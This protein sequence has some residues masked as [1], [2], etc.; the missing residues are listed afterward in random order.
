GLKVQVPLDGGAPVVSAGMRVGP[1]GASVGSDGTLK[2]EWGRVRVETTPESGQVGFGLGTNVALTRVLPYEVSAGVSL[3]LADP[4]RAP[5][6]AWGRC[7]P[8]APR[9]LSEGQRWDA[10]PPEQREALQSAGVRA[11]FWDALVQAAPRAP[12][13]QLSSEP[14][15]RLVVPLPR[16]SAR[17]AH[18]ES[19]PDG[20]QALPTRRVRLPATL[21]S[22]PTHAFGAGR[23]LGGHGRGQAGGLLGAPWVQMAEHA[24][25]GTTAADHVLTVLGGDAVAAAGEGSRDEGDFATAACFGKCGVRGL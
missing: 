22:T 6:I 10:L 2:L 4:R 1:A 8:D 19:A 13:R 24:D 18:G 14:G 3:Q 5:A 21:R 11:T 9:A 16:S 7:A 23:G 17:P 20:A 15:A 25:F 12:S